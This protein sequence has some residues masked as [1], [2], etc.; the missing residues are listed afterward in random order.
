VVAE[1]LNTVLSTA[2]Q[3]LSPQFNNL[4]QDLASGASRRNKDVKLQGSMEPY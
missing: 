2:A 1:N 4:N 3:A